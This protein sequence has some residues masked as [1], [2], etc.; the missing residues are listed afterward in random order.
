MGAFAGDP[1]PQP[2]TAKGRERRKKLKGWA[3]ADLR[4]LSEVTSASSVMGSLYLTKD[5]LR[6]Y[7]GWAIFASD[8]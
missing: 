1:P 2:R 4:Y 8:T 5:A 6:V 7:S 3:R